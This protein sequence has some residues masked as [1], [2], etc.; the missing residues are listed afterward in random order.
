M[1]KETFLQGKPVERLRF[2]S[3]PPEGVPGLDPRQLLRMRKEVYGSVAVPSQWR[4]SLMEA[5]QGLGWKM[6]DMD[7]CIFMLKSITAV[8]VDGIH[9]DKHSEE[10]ASPLPDSA[11]T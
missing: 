8:A 10:S 6:R 5:T 3:Q 9:K 4:D 1:A 2:V 11:P 7:P